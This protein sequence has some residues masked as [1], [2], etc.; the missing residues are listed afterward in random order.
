PSNPPGRSIPSCSHPTPPR[1]HSSRSFPCHSHSSHSSR[2]GYSAPPRS[3]NSMRTSPA[4]TVEQD[5][6]LGH[7][8]LEMRSHRAN[9][10]A[11]LGILFMGSNASFWYADSDSTIKSRFIPVDSDDFVSAIM[12]LARAN[13]A[14]L[15][16]SPHFRT[17]DGS[18]LTSQ[19][20]EGARFIVDE[21][22]ALDTAYTLGDI[23]SL[24]RA[25]HGRCSRA[26][27]ATRAGRQ[28]NY[29]LKLSHQVV[30]RANE[31]D[32]IKRAQ[33]REVA[34]LVRL[35]DSFTLKKLSEGPRSRLPPDLIPGMPN[36][37]LVEDRELRVLVLARCMPLYSVS[38]P[39]SFLKACISLLHTICD[40]YEIGDIMHQDISVNNLMVEM[41][42]PGVGV[43]IDLDRAV[44]HR[45]DGN[46]N[47]SSLHRTG[48]LPFMA[49]DLLHDDDK[50][51][52]HLRHDLESFL[53]VLF[54]IAGRYESGSE[55]NLETFN[56][57]CEGSW[58]KISTFKHGFI[59][60]SPSYKQ[61]KPTHGFSFF[62]DGILSF[63]KLLGNAHTSVTYEHQSKIAGLASTQGGNDYPQGRSPSKRQR[64]HLVPSIPYPPELK[65]VNRRDL[66][67]ILNNALLNLGQPPPGS[68]TG[69]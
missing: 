37:L 48:T 15:G 29:V 49:L 58:D 19:P 64:L 36:H 7:Y 33:K 8:L 52:H 63:R 23:I 66:D 12:C 16:Y 51:P 53:Y 26:L 43:L 4:L 1:S 41:D 65:G 24:A 18:V 11:V 34:G 59:T 60:F 39:H 35:Y 50:Y 30:S 40:L 45:I 22:A 14:R 17:S 61:F 20:I 9:R 62:S 3:S 47:A 21:T 56:E 25:L 6:R 57:W 27:G 2:S 10:D 44:D 13:P 28:E 38:D 5:I 68:S 69:A 42:N 31:A 55:V 46:N 32:L 54:W 67:L